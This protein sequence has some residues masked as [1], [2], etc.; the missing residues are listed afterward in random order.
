[1]LNFIFRLLLLSDEII[2]FLKLSGANANANANTKVDK[3]TIVGR[4][5]GLPAKVLVNEKV[6]TEIDTS[7]TKEAGAFNI[8]VLISMINKQSEAIQQLNLQLSKLQEDVSAI[9]VTLN[10]FVDKIEY[11]PG[12]EISQLASIDYA[13]H[14]RQAGC[15]EK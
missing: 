13:E 3:I 15:V 4:L 11:A 5:N 14:L 12:N 7:D 1:M 10:E 9:K 8:Q 6:V 2:K